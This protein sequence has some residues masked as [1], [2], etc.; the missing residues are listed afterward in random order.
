MQMGNGCAP[1][2]RS[3]APVWP[4]G[5]HTGKRTPRG[6]TTKVDD[7]AGESCGKFD[8]SGFKSAKSILSMKI[9]PIPRFLAFLFV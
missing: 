5:D 6:F 9:L 3:S 8:F 1:E 4:F 7:F 2:Q